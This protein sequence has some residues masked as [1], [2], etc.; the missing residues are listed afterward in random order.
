MPGLVN[1]VQSAI[2]RCKGFAFEFALNLSL[3]ENRHRTMNLFRTLTGS[4][5]PLPA[6]L[7]W[8]VAWLS[9]ASLVSLGTGSG[10]A[11]A[12]ACLGVVVASVLGNSGWRRLMIV[13]G[14][15]LSMAL[16]GVVSLPPWAWLLPMG[17]LLLMYPFRAWRDAPFF[18]TP[19]DALDA[20]THHAPLPVG[21]LVLDAGC[22]V[23][24]GLR[25]LRR[26]YPE[27]RLH[28]LEWSW[29]LR[30][31]CAV[32]CPWA[33]VRQGDMWAHDWSGYAMVYLFQRPESMPRAV[34][35]ARSELAA[36]AWLVSLE[37]EVTELQAYAHT[38]APGGKIVWIYQAPFLPPHDPR[39]RA[40]PGERS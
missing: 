37:F 4:P 24:H 19:Y 29:P 15:P 16:T 30:A 31:V 1:P 22:G 10:L 3:F 17:L 6:L 34:I 32:W 11:F 25:A 9:F 20:L 12:L 2:C 40:A 23:G 27:A 5:W 8:A 28:G 26:T 7:V 35:K 39:F 13:G 38:I 21:A 36:G 33:Q 14:F 18:P